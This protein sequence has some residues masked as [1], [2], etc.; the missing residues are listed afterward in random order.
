M[1]VAAVSVPLSA[2]VSH[3]FL[4]R[5]PGQI[6][7]PQNDRRPDRGRIYLFHPASVFG[8]SP[9][10][11]VL[12]GLEVVDIPHECVRPQHVVSVRALSP[13]PYPLLSFCGSPRL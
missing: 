6:D 4:N 11:Q 13:W 9:V 10:A 3:L 8:T 1:L 7:C 5:D 12:F 2:L